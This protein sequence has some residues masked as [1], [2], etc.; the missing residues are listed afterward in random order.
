MAGSAEMNDLR[1]AALLGLVGVMVHNFVDFGLHI[2]SNT[3][4][5]IALASAA[6]SIV[7]P[8]Q[9]AAKKLDFGVTNN[10]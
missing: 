5:F 7:K 10:R 4:A 6:C 1:I 8:Q 3:L 2:P 9:N